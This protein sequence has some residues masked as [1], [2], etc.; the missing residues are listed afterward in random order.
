MNLLLIDSEIPGLDKFIKS[1]NSNTKMIVYHS[2]I[3]TFKMLDKKIAELKISRYNNLG[4]VFV[5]DYNIEKLFINDI[6]F[7]TYNQS[8]ILDNLSTSF[9]TYLIR[10][11]QIKTI[12]FLAC[13]LL[14]EPNWK[15]Y[16]NYI[17]SKNGVSVRASNDLTGNLSSGGDWILESTGENIEKL[18]FNSN[19][20]YWNY[21]LDTSATSSST[22][23]ISSDN[24]NNLYSCGNNGNG[25]LGL[26][27]TNSI[28]S[29]QTVCNFSANILNK[30]VVSVVS[31]AAFSLVITNE[32]TNNLY[33]CG[34]NI[35]GQLGLG[36]NSSRTT[37]QNAT[38]GISDK[39]IVAISAGEL[40]SLLLTNDSSNNLYSCGLNSSGQLGLG[41]S[42]DRN[43]FQNVTT[44][45]S[46][47]T[48][49]A[50]N[51]GNDYSFLLT[52][53]SSNNLYSCGNN[54][55]GQLG[56]G[57]NTNRNTF[58]IVTSGISGK[59]VLSASGGTGQSLILTNDISNNLYGCGDCVS[60]KLGFG[61]Y[62]S[63]YMTNNTTDI[64][65]KPY[66]N[67]VYIANASSTNASNLPYKAFDVDISGSS[68][69]S[70]L[71]Y[72]NVSGS[73]I[74]NT[75]TTITG[76]FSISGEWLELKLPDTIPPIQLSGFYLA[77]ANSTIN[78]RPKH[79]TVVGSNVS[80]NPWNILY[81]NSSLSWINNQVTVY[82]T[83]LPIT[84]YRYYRIIIQS[85]FGDSYTRI[86]TWSLFD[87]ITTFK[88]IPT[89]VKNGKYINVSAGGSH[90]LLLTNDSSNNFYSTGL[91]FSG[92]VGNT[93]N[94]M[95]ASFNK[96][97][98]SIT[99]KY[100]NGISSGS[101]YSLVT[102]SE[103]TNNFYVTGENASGQ[104][105]MSSNSNIYI[106]R[107]T[108]I[109]IYG[110]KII[111]NNFI[112][113][114]TPTTN[115]FSSFTYG[116]NNMTYYPTA[117]DNDNN[118][119]SIYNVYNPEALFP[120][121]I[122]T[123]GEAYRMTPV[124]TVF[125][126]PISFTV[127]FLYLS[128]VYY[129]YN[130]D[131][132][133][134]QMNTDSSKLPY[135]V[136]TN[137][138]VT[139]YSDTILA[140]LVFTA[141][142]SNSG[143]QFSNLKKLIINSRDSP[144]ILPNT[145]LNCSFYTTPSII[146]DISGWDVSSSIT[147]SSMFRDSSF[148]NELSSWKPN[149]VKDMSYMFYGASNFNK[150]ISYNP[151]NKTWD[152]SGVTNMSYIFNK[153]T[154]F[155]NS[156]L[157]MSGTEP[158]NWNL[159]PNVNVNISNDVSYSEL[160][161][162]NAQKITSELLVYL[163]IGIASTTELSTGLTTPY[164]MNFYNEDGTIGIS[165][166]TINNTTNTF[167]GSRYNIAGD[168]VWSVKINVPTISAFPGPNQG[169]IA[170]DLSRNVIMSGKWYNNY[171]PCRFYDSDRNLNSSLILPWG[172]NASSEEN[173]FIVKYDT[174]GFSQ[175]RN[176][177]CF[178][179]SF[180]SHRISNTCCDISGNIYST[181]RFNGRALF[182][183]SNSTPTTWA[184][185]SSV[186]LL[187][188]NQPDGFLAKYDKDGS[189]VWLAKMTS[190]NYEE[191]YQTIVDRAN[192]IY[193]VGYH[194]TSGTQIYNGTLNGFGTLYTTVPNTGS[195]F[196][197]Y[198]PNGNVLW[199]TYFSEN[200]YAT[201]LGYALSYDVYVGG[202]Y[203]GIPPVFKNRDNSVFTTL[204]DV[205]ASNSYVVKYT[206][207]GFG[208][209]TSRMSTDTNQLYI[210]ITGICNE[211]QFLDISYPQQGLKFGI[212]NGYFDTF[213]GYTNKYSF[214]Y[215]NYP[216][217]TGIT[218]NFTNILTS[219]NNLFTVSGELIS[220]CW[221]GYFKA[222][223]T[224][225]YI[226]STTSV[227]ASYL[228]ING[229]PIV[230]NGG[231]H[232]SQTITGTCKLIAGTYYY[233]QIFYGHSREE[234]TF[235]ASYTEPGG[236][237]I[238]NA[239]ELNTYFV[240][241]GDY[242]PLYD[243]WINQ[244]SY[245]LNNI[246]IITKNENFFNINTRSN[247]KI[248]MYRAAVNPYNY[249]YIH[250]KY[251]I[252]SITS[253]S[254]PYTM[255]INYGNSSYNFSESRKVSY[256]YPTPISN[257]LGRWQNAV[258]DMT[259]E[260]N[261]YM[262]N[263]SDWILVPLNGESNIQFEYFFI[264]DS[265]ILPLNET[266]N[267]V[268]VSFFSKGDIT[269]IYNSSFYY[270]TSTN[271]GY[272]GTSNS[273]FKSYTSNDSYQQSYIIKYNPNGQCLWSIILEGTLDVRT[274]VIRVDKTGYVYVFGHFGTS[275]IIRDKNNNICA[276]YN[277]SIDDRYDTFIAVYTSNGDYL[278]SSRQESIENNYN[279]SYYNDVNDT[280]SYFGPSLAM[281]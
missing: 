68:W 23:V 89:S 51:C 132:E 252:S 58:Q 250:I 31:G 43:T 168:A 79:I 136:Y 140:Y 66:G 8:G 253:G 219:T 157:D 189:G 169:S 47:K 209:W 83:T 200:I 246:T 162:A 60:G 184:D 40:Y 135:Y 32:L 106:L 30:K 16:F 42:L 114:N 182:Q 264:T 164:T 251:R 87:S 10:K 65:G 81:S 227:N 278:W 258:I 149:E 124:S 25:Q 217:A 75:L 244:N 95:S 108:V 34:N 94:R 54:R 127:N 133:L 56:L 159:N 141:P 125:A 275:I 137:S 121:L 263:W 98:N 46:G 233:I 195:W 161:V 37:F 231:I 150:K 266:G 205:S 267:N 218:S 49:K 242:N 187:V 151:T 179:T 129:Q 199:S 104:L 84:S 62:P 1:S 59:K 254:T 212:Y 119:I 269:N 174:N 197:K 181:G 202:Y 38:L 210:N 3:V 177:L 67:G 145:R 206:N 21:L 69:R 249:K 80:G 109:N 64:S 61:V 247:P 7:I 22:L 222:N 259:N 160:T 232:T 154:T 97:Y 41:D 134:I 201:R 176:R 208:S 122:G 36:D 216:Y 260:K 9:I 185:I 270:D 44:G 280:N 256:V 77:S 112:N 237:N 126:S 240:A 268:Y 100:Y 192:N 48:I 196:T 224:G 128:N 70:T 117:Q 113:T 236:D 142:P 78:A 225:T 191:S 235:S 120:T 152:V 19:I 155:N 15:K 146:G 211:K 220:I 257:I 215:S 71:K 171:G 88:N 147:M 170:S 166:E 175:W 28:F 93:L 82:L 6:P 262:D 72:N 221:W 55:L 4:F 273:L 39:I 74:G 172:G 223:K 271:F 17:S 123:V 276:T 27:N 228:M 26:G 156:Q 86:S 165:N 102:T 178:D 131:S 50:I 248:T 53:D 148:N 73:Y 5:N 91:I 20:S 183:N 234:Y 45:I 188:T 243:N 163:N 92:E 239:T 274:T 226:F 52:T 186:G 203:S 12:D 18:Y 281:S 194:D 198:G 105:D 116:T 24:S 115:S 261:W 138:T 277:T 118:V 2:K 214:F 245:L 103:P 14:S 130:T 190:N 241:P 85:N 35:N 111:F 33:S 272:S 99:N 63:Y 57:D 29:F 107:N 238:S 207:D 229:N 101:N 279:I 204:T 230:N 144:V 167:F 90:S 96:G 143:A 173:S 255:T 139:I 76:G 110:K 158:M 193:C 265:P 11:Y 13:S 153:A 213:P 180:S